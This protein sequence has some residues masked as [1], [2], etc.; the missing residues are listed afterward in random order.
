M[1]RCKRCDS[2]IY[3]CE[4]PR[5]RKKIAFSLSNGKQHSQECEKIAAQKNLI[6][7][8]RVMA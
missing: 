8:E 2:K 4:Q 3:F 7:R 1:A 5:T 6:E